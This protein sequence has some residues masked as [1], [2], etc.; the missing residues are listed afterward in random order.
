MNRWTPPL[1][2]FSQRSNTRLLPAL[3]DLKSAAMTKSIRGSRNGGK[4]PRC[5]ADPQGRDAPAKLGFKFAS[6]DRA[7]IERSD[8]T[9]ASPL[10]LVFFSA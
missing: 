9:A 7:P 2:E 8:A 4:A 1:R 6:G 5:L 3:A 10:Q